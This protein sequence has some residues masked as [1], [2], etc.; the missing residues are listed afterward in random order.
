MP[1]ARPREFDILAAPPRVLLSN[2]FPFAPGQ[3]APPF[4]CESSF[5]LLAV[6]GRGTIRIGPK[7]FDLSSGQVV[8]VPWS[9]PIGLTADHVDPF[10]VLSVLLSYE[11]W[12][13]ASSGA[14]RLHITNV[15][16]TRVSYQTPPHPQLYMDAFLVNTPLDSPLPEIAADIAHTYETSITG[17]PVEMCEARLRGLALTFVAEF[18]Q[19]MR[20]GAHQIQSRANAAQVRMVREIASFMGLSL[21]SPEMEHRT[22]LAERAGVSEAT[23]A[24]AFRAV[25]GRG[26]IDYLIELRMSHARRALRT[27]RAKVGEIAAQV[28]IPNIYYFSKLFKKRVGCSP[29]QYRTRLKI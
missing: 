12:S 15:D 4:W 20:A 6:R 3:A 23:L 19:C 7:E 18:Q 25:T 14:A 21:A 26:P 11:P 29:L 2:F 9:S 17:E 28:G 16:Q 13:S 27:S 22:A 8:H 10:T 1:K 5:F 24:R